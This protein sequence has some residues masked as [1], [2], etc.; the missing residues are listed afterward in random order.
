MSELKDGQKID[1]QKLIDDEVTLH[2]EISKWRDDLTVD[3][4]LLNSLKEGQIQSIIFRLLKSGK[5]EL[6]V[7]SRR[8]FHQKLLGTPWQEI[9]K[10]IREVSDRDA[11]LMAASE[12]IFRKDF[13][14]WEE[15]RAI[16]SLLAGKFTIKDLA[17]RFGVSDSYIRSR[18]DLLRLPKKIRNKF[19]AK[20]V[21][22]SYASSVLKL[23]TFEEAQVE[24]VDEI[25]SGLT[26]GYSGI[27]TVEKADEFVARVIK[28]KED[29][30]ALVAKYGPC[31][32]CGSKQIF[33]RGWGDENQLSCRECN[34]SWHKVTKEPWEYY[35][36]KQKAEEMGYKVE[37]GPETVK[38]TPKEMAE[39]I[40]GEAEKQSEEEEEESE[41]K[42]PEKFRSWIPLEAIIA[43]L[44][45]DN[46]QKIDVS[47]QTL[48]IQFIENPELS[49]MGYRKDYK[50][51][52]KAR[53]EVHSGW[54]SNSQEQTAKIHDLIKRLSEQVK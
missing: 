12:N 9:G 19:E 35:E 44:I 25:V 51:G 27:R 54:S 6:L 43:P 42:L 50:S 22:M 4:K 34:H 47:G 23:E 33:E 52:E 16:G 28:R 48:E 1:T 24:L 37:E 2:P 15:A 13:S 31:P 53:I 11:L 32:K 49:F 3:L 18:R 46:I 20:N 39:M 5:H 7:G 21:P 38:F 40:K 45:A 30:E 41:E 17:K 14:P 8:Y 10:E 29:M 26:S 36:M